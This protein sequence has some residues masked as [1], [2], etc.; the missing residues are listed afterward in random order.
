[1]QLETFIAKEILYELLTADI[2]LAGLVGNNI[3]DTVAPSTAIEPFIIFNRQS[4]VPLITLDHERP[5]VN[6]EYLVKAITKG[7][8]YMPLKPI[9]E[10]IDNIL[11]KFIGQSA[12][13]F[14]D[15]IERL[16]TIEYPEFDANGIQYMHLG[17][18][19]SIIVRS[20]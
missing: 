4:E 15:I 20:K 18:I 3:Y 6:Y 5:L 17:A 8:S 11:D 12:T 16:S 7:S 19:Y 2:Q 10:R 1:M 13:G 14:I 9:V